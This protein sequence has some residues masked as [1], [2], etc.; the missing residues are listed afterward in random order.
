MIAGTVITRVSVTS[1]VVR[2]GCSPWD[3]R[4]LR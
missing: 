1:E 3:V 4:E 2:V